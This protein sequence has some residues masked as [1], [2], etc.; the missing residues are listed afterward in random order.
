[1]HGSVGESIN[2]GNELGAFIFQGG[3]MKACRLYPVIRNK[4]NLYHVFYISAVHGSY[5]T[6]FF[7][8][9]KGV[10]ALVLIGSAI[11]HSTL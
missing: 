3:N 2:K 8:I 6:T 4:K 11:N 9:G 10:L 1:M 7:E 5:R